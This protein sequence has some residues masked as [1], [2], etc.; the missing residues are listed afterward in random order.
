MGPDRKSGQMPDNSLK[1]G[2][3]I[4]LHAFGPAEGATPWWVRRSGLYF[5]HI[6]IEIGGYVLDQ[7]RWGHP[8]CHEV[9]PF[10]QE[11]AAQGKRIYYRMEFTVWTDIPAS[12]IEEACRYSEAQRSNGFTTALRWLR[13]WPWPVWNCC[14]PS[15]RILKEI[16]VELRGETPDAII[17]EVAE[18]SGGLADSPASI[19]RD[20][21]LM[22]RRL[23]SEE[24]IQQ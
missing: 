8:S 14:S 23:G 20:L 17:E 4:V 1:T 2:L 5:T 16:G 11:K 18:I 19:A 6:T 9:L 15:K 12:A 7:P 24:S 10:L 3:S 22:G 21:E 13:L